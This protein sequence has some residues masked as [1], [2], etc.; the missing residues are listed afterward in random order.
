MGSKSFAVVRL[1]IAVLCAGMAA[2]SFARTASPCALTPGEA[3]AQV[4][5]VLAAPQEAFM[6][7]R[8]RAALV[9]LAEAVEALD[10]RLEA[11]VSASTANT[12]IHA[13]KGIIIT[14]PPASE[15]R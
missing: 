9:C 10:A 14:Q 7:D 15:D 11:S 2:P 6:T 3:A 4:R 1:V 5:K 12:P 13:P 8:D